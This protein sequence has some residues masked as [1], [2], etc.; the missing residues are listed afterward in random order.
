[1]PV[2]IPVQLSEMTT[3]ASPP[4]PALL[5]STSLSTETW[6]FLRDMSSPPS[7]KA[8]FLAVINASFPVVR[9]S[10]ASLHKC[11]KPLSSKH[12]SR[13]LRLKASAHFCVPNRECTLP[14]ACT[15]F[16]SSSTCTSSLQ[17]CLQKSYLQRCCSHR[18]P[19]TTMTY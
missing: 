18:L 12:V 17:L 11:T 8:L 14:E 4:L 9:S 15:A 6:H 5:L 10:Q 1:M 3:P 13:S 16:A 19:M 2:S 7:L